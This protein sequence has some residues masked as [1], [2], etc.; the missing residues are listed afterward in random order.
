[1]DLRFKDFIAECEEL[2]NNQLEWINLFKHV[3]DEDEIKK[4]DVFIMASMINNNKESREGCLSKFDWGFSTDSFGKATF[5]Q[6]GGKDGKIVFFAGNVYDDFGEEYE[7]L[8]ASRYF[9]GDYPPVIEVNPELVWYGNLA[10]TSEGFID[11]IS[12]EIKIKI[13]NN[14]VQIRRDYL[15]DYLAAKNKLC[16]IA[17]DNRRFVKTI[18]KVNKDYIQK[19][20]NNYNYSIA[21]QKDTFSEYDYYSSI[22]GKCIIE[23]YKEPL[24]EAY[25]YFFPDSTE[26][27]DFIIG[28]DE[29]NGKEVTYTCNEDKLSNFFGKNQ[30]APQFLTPVFF[31][32]DVMDRYTNN[33]AQ[34]SVAD[35]HIMYLNIWSLPYTINKNDKVTVWLGDLG[36]IPYKEQQYW[37]VFNIKP[38]GEVNDKFV[39]RQLYAQWT[40]SIGEEKTLFSQIEKINELTLNKFNELLFKELS[41]GDNQ[42]K[43]AFIIP[44]NSSLTQYQNFLLQLNK[45]TIER[46]NTKLFSKTVDK[47]KLKNKE[48]KMYGSRIQFAIFLNEIGFSNAKDC[49]KHFKLINDCRNKLAGHSASIPQYNELWERNEDARIDSIKD[50]KYLLENL[51][52]HLAILIDEIGE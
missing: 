9:E 6:Y 15:K 48:G 4:D 21:I 1:M 34:Y 2:A 7:Y 13:T 31:T 36:R 40:D 47:D 27:V 8:V 5:Y 16:V 44:S 46:L 32:K 14:H 42:L 35:D 50:S 24:H 39:Q 20:E 43:S 26:Y 23:P 37:R 18:D 41:D 49:D 3:I 17:F 30:G 29:N 19:K 11:S 28:L 38:E 12:N 22:L 52:K 51:N 33:P 25:R 45:L 10:K